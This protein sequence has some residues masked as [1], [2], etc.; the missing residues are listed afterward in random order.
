M[1]DLNELKFSLTMNEYHTFHISFESKLS[2]IFQLLYNSFNDNE[3]MN[4]Q[5]LNRLITVSAELMVI[6]DPLV[7]NNVSDEKQRLELRTKLTNEQNILRQSLEQLR[8]IGTKRAV[9][10]FDTF[11]TRT[12]ALKTIFDIKDENVK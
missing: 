3:S 1:D 11:D 12:K 5:N 6:D 8:D 10:N 2:F 9:S 7:V 4:N